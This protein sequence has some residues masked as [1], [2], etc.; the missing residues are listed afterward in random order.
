MEFSWL[1]SVAEAIRAEAPGGRAVVLSDP[2]TCEVLSYFGNLSG[3]DSQYWE[4]LEGLRAAADI[5]TAR[6]DD[7][8]LE[9]IRRR[10]ITHIVLIRTYEPSKRFFELKYGRYDPNE[11]FNTFGSKM[12]VRLLPAW[13]R[14][15]RLHATAREFEG[16][17]A[18]VFEV[19]PRSLAAAAAPR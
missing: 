13:L 17:D 16:L 5:Y 10:G 15:V 6:T 9:L 2:G 3:I 14:R 19:D 18:D 11:A 8:A 1:R 7:E 12:H 4:N